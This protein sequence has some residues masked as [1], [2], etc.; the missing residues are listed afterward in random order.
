MANFA[1]V[2][3]H[4]EARG[5]TVSCFATAAEAC[6]YLDRTLDSPGYGPCRAAGDA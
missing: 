4:L 1:R 3:E 2:R 6:D 5:F